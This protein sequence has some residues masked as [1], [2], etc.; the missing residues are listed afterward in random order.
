[1]RAASLALRRILDRRRSII[2]PEDGL[3]LNHSAYVENAAHAILLAVDRPEAAAGQIYNCGDE[4]LL[5]LDDTVEFFNL[6]LGDKLTTQE[7]Q[8]LVAFMRAL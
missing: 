3:T 1:M 7:K 5:T 6:V 2:L 4:R 8:D